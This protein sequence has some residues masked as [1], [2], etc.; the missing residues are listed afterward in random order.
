MLRSK[1]RKIQQTWTKRS[2]EEIMTMWLSMSKLNVDAS[3]GLNFAL[4]LSNEALN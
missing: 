3:W 2:S 1:C 4:F